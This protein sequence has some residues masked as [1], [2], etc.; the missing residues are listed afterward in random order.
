MIKTLKFDVPTS[1]F[2][3]VYFQKRYTLVTLVEFVAFN[4]RKPVFFLLWCVSGAYTFF[5][6]LKMQMLSFIPQ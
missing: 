5:G 4:D 1:I 6:T 2:Y 3:Q